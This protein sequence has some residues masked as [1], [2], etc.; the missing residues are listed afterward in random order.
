[1]GKTPAQ[2]PQSPHTCGRQPSEK[3]LLVWFFLVQSWLPRPFLSTAWV[4]TPARQSPDTLRLLGL[5]GGI[6]PQQLV[7]TFVFPLHT[8]SCLFLTIV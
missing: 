8:G 5:T 4:E 6:P 3:V 7:T 1:M 2:A